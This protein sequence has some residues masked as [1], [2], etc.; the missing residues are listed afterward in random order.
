MTALEELLFFFSR[1]YSWLCLYAWQHYEAL[2]GRTAN[3]GHV[4]DIYSCALDQTG[5]HEM[6]FL[7]SSTGLDMFHQHCSHIYTKLEKLFSVED[8]GQIDHI[9]KPTCAGLCCCCWPRPC[10]AVCLTTLVHS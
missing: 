5:L 2:A 4:V 7:P 3:N 6:K 10:Y 8:R 9:T 1:M